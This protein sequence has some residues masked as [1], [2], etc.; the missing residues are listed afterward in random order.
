MKITVCSIDEIKYRTCAYSETLMNSLLRMGQGF[1]IHVKK[2][3]STYECIDGHKRLSA[4][5]DILKKNPDHS[6]SKI[7]ILVLNN[8]RTP[9]GTPKNHH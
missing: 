4:V 5:C 8:A 1:P 6:L 3:G 9:G 2:K 7:K